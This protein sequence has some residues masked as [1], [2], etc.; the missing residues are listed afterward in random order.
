VL[1]KQVA[2]E[3]RYFWMVLQKRP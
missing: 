2:E 3:H 1:P